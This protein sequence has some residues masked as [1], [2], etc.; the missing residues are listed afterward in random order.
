ML[1]KKIKYSIKTSTCIEKSVVIQATGRVSSIVSLLSEAPLS[2]AFDLTVCTFDGV[3][4][5]L[6]IQKR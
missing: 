6:E 4:Q 5:P 1:N 2:R 3:I